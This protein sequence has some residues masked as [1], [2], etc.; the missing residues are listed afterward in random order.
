MQPTQY[1]PHWLKPVPR[2]SWEIKH[3]PV[4]KLN[5]PTVDSARFTF[6]SLPGML[7]LGLAILISVLALSTFKYGLSVFPCVTVAFW[8]TN[9]CYAC[10]WHAIPWHTEHVLHIFARI[11]GVNPKSHLSKWCFTAVFWSRKSL[12]KKQICFLGYEELYGGL[13]GSWPVTWDKAPSPISLGN[14]DVR[15]SLQM[16][17]CWCPDLWLRTKP[18]L[19]LS[20]SDT[21]VY[22]H[23]HSMG[24]G[25]K[26][27][28]LGLLE[29]QPILAS[30]T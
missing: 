3:V 6:W 15:T 1:N 7:S 29:F 18:E 13:R 22:S 26:M 12:D 16:F 19:A 24:N 9:V 28:W 30:T 4:G 23:L 25:W 20:G 2:G 11:F 17:F 27:K 21:N 10:W 14:V 8:S 5:V